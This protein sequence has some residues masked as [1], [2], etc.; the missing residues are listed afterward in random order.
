MSGWHAT[1]HCEW[2]PPLQQHCN[3]KWART[4]QTVERLAKGWMVR[5]SNAGGVEIFLT[6]PDRPWGPPSH[7][8]N[9]YRVS[10]PGI[11]RPGRGFE[12]T[13]PS[14]TE[15]QDRVDSVF[16]IWVFMAFFRVDFTF[17]F[18]TVMGVQRR[19]LSY[20]SDGRGFDSDAV[21]EISYS[22]NPSSRTMILGSIR[23]LTKIRTRDLLWGIKVAGA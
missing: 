11:K 9:W 6:R 12:H 17:T 18:F 13:L 19:A 5:G 15:V 7:L 10:F 14:R 21:F 23:P 1:G 22:L 20:K 8:Y 2:H 16:P 4:A 3:E